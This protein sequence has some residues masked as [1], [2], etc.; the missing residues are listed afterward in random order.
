MYF[1]EGEGAYDSSIP[2]EEREKIGIAI[3]AKSV[4]LQDVE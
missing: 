3:L 1:S 2:R 4:F